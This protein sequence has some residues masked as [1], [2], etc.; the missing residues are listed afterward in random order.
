MAAGRPAVTTDVGCCRELLE[1]VDDDLGTA[2][3]CVPPMHQSAL[4]EAMLAMCDNQAERLRMGEIGQKRVS[5]NYRH[6]QMLERYASLFD[7][8][9]GEALGGNRI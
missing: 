7:E 9:G 5:A 1:G 4:A 2:G 8:A 6:A 3:F